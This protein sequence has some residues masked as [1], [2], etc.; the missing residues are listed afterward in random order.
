MN[1]SDIQ[2]ISKDEA[3]QHDKYI[4]FLHIQTLID[5]YPNISRKA[6]LIEHPVTK[7]YRED[8]IQNFKE[9]IKSITSISTL[10]K[11]LVLIKQFQ[12]EYPG[13]IDEIE[14]YPDF[15]VSCVDISNSFDSMPDKVLVWEM[16]EIA[17]SMCGMLIENIIADNENVIE[18]E[19][20]NDM[21]SSLIS[22]ESNLTK[23]QFIYFMKR[24]F[25]DVIYGDESTKNDPLYFDRTGNT[26]KGPDNEDVY[27]TLFFKSQNHKL[28]FSSLKHFMKHDLNGE[29]YINSL[30]LLDYILNHEIEFDKLKHDIQH[31][32]MI[33]NLYGETNVIHGLHLRTQYLH[34]E[35]DFISDK[36]ITDIKVY[37][38]YEPNLWFAQLYLY[39]KM[40]VDSKNEVLSK[41]I[42]NPVKH[43]LRIVN[44]FT[45]KVYTFTY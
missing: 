8:I 21:T 14:T 16:N 44:M 45:N 41:V 13:V 12:K 7:L 3:K 36:S 40:F 35:M 38:T 28:I 24:K 34:G 11:K 26:R 23:E 9:Y 27:E 10:A 25:V 43:T 6:I 4:I 32:T 37:K 15:N 5:Q 30:K 29:D 2:F 22:P 31:A 17:P 42:P 19:N 33:K 20:I 39:E 18:C 1:V